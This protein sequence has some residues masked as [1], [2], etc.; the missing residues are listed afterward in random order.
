MEPVADDLMISN[1]VCFD[2]GNEVNDNGYPPTHDEDE[3]ASEGTGAEESSEDDESSEVSRTDVDELLSDS[4]VEDAFQAFENYL[5]DAV[6]EKALRQTY[7][8]PP[9]NNTKLLFKHVL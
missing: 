9:P 3:C 5:G 2:H 4:E 8:S 1:G 6:A 7:C